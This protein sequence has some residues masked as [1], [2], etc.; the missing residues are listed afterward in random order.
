MASAFQSV[1]TRTAGYSTFSQAGMHEETRFLEYPFDV[2]RRITWRN[3][4]R[5]EDYYYSNAHAYMHCICPWGQD[6]ECFEEEYPHKMSEW[7]L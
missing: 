1:T 4:R 2:Y 7:D 6:T 3:G 5:C